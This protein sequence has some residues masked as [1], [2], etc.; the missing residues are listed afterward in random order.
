MAAIKEPQPS[1]T[2]LPQAPET[3]VRTDAPSPSERGLG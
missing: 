2:S 3:N 1:I